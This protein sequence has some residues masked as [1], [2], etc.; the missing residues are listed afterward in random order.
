MLALPMY[1]NPDGGAIVL[2]NSSGFVKLCNS[3]NAAGKRIK[4]E[5]FLIAIGKIWFPNKNPATKPKVNLKK[6]NFFI[7]LLLLLI[8]KQKCLNNF[9]KEVIKEVAIMG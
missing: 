1:I 6:F 2:P 8:V 3:M 4:Q 9:P 5:D 7:T